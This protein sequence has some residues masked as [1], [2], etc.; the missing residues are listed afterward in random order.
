MAWGLHQVTTQARSAVF[1]SG[2]SSSSAFTSP[3]EIFSHVIRKD[4][5]LP[6]EPIIRV[7]GLYSRIL[8]GYRFDEYSTLDALKDNRVP[9]LFVHGKEDKFVPTWMSQKNYD[10]CP[11]KKRLLMVENAGHGSSIFENRELYERTEREF[12]ADVVGD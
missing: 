11:S 6:P 3:G 8:S 9:V 2:S 1:P 4:Y 5:H 12:L 10:T 7:N